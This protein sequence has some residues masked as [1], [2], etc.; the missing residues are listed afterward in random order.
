MNVCYAIQIWNQSIHLSRKEQN[1]VPMHI[2]K[3][4]TTNTVAHEDG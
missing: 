4:H 2:L 3:A 1:L